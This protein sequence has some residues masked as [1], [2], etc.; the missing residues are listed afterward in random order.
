MVLV[1]QTGSNV[2]IDGLTRDGVADMQGCQNSADLGCCSHHAQ[3]AEDA[4]AAVLLAP[5]WA[6]TQHR[7]AQVWLLCDCTASRAN[8]CCDWQPASASAPLHCARQLPCLLLACDVRRT[9]AGEQLLPD[10]LPAAGSA[11]APC[12]STHHSLYAHCI[13]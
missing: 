7:L 10:A 1:G 13:F 5:A 3:A 2:W 8:I 12:T 6:K 4:E 11:R 9:S